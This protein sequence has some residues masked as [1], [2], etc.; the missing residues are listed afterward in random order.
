MDS[1]RPSAQA[2]A[3]QAP[4][5]R[6]REWLFVLTG[7]A[8]T[9]RGRFGLILTLF[10]VLVAAVGPEFAPYSPTAFVTGAFATPARQTLLGG[11]ELG[12]DVLSRV[13]AGGWLLLVLALVSTLLGL[14]A[15][16]IAGMAAAYRRGFSDGLIMRCV[17][18][19]LAFPQLIFA[20]MLVSILGSKLW[21]LVV[22][23]GL[24]HAP[25]VARVVRSTTLDISERDYV[26]AAEIIGVRPWRVMVRDILPNLT[27]PLMVEAGIRLTYSISILAGLSF[28]GFGLQPPAPNWGTMINENRIGL[29]ENPWGVLAPA[30]LIAMLT[31]GLN[32]FT[33]AVARVSLGVDRVEE[34]VVFNLLPTDALK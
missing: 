5:H 22:A 30:I 27:T 23:I 24:A 14:V 13:L 25:Q 32:T 2:P 12:R 19:L 21:L 18:V 7:A 26:H 3:R 9:P 4:A 11:D 34:A 17:D 20:L 29:T 8:K 16:T 1:E 6:R 15:G 31:V 10:V 28:L 33:D